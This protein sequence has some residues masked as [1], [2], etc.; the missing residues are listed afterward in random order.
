MAS[1]PFTDPAFYADRYPTYAA[2][3]AAAPVLQVPLGPTTAT[4]VT[5]YEEA[6]QAFTAALSKDTGAYFADKPSGRTLHPAVSHTMLATDPPEHTRL[7]RLVTKAFTSAR[8]DALRPYIRALAEELVASW[9]PG[10][11]VD[12][13]EELAGPLP[14]TVICQLLGVPPADRAAI[15]SWST[16]LFA[17]GDHQRIDAASHALAGYLAELITGKRARPD[18]ALLSD[19]IAVHDGDA[20]R[21]SEDELLSLAVLLLVAGHETT[22]A[23]IGNAVLALLRHPAELEHLRAD[24]HHLRAA[25]DELLRYDAPV[26]VATWR[27]AP[28]EVELGDTRVPAG[29]PVF[30]CPG[31]A[32][33]DPARFP[34]PD[35][36][37]LRRADAA[38]HL[39]FGHGIHRCLGA[40]L[41][42]AEIE[43][44]LGVLLERF[45]GLRLAA[46]ADRL[47]WRRSRLVRGLIALPV[48]L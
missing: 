6:R 38:G 39:A 1:S 37:D 35:R 26:S 40:P 19:L 22:T 43:I 21:L 34:H 9:E 27:W 48:S 12:L 13:V 3:R 23:A 10:D 8:V 4:V 5:G 29:S 15:R 14:V 33:R 41:A 46:P 25:V 20:D 18:G 7:R 47:R 16:D 11:E 30:V 32:N 24:P 44:V 28:E 31:A 45:P 2:L 42:H 17:T 36:L